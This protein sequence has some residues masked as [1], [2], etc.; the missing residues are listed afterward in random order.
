MTTA[1]RLPGNPGLD[2]EAAR[3]AATV[4]GGHT[5]RPA[6][7]ANAALLDHPPGRFFVEDLV[8]SATYSAGYTPSPGARWL[9][10]RWRTAPSA[11]ITDTAAVD[12]TLRD[13]GGAS[14]VSSNAMVPLGFKG[15][16][17]Y[18][19][20]IFALDRFT[21]CRSHEGWLDL[22]ALRSTLT[23][24]DWSLDFAVTL[25]GSGEVR[26]LEGWE[27][28]RNVLDD[29]VVAR[30]ILPGAF[31]PLRPV[32][33]GTPVGLERLLATIEAAR[34]TIRP[35]YLSL[36]FP[37][38]TT[39]ACPYV[40][41]TS[42]A[43]F[44]G[45]DEGASYVTLQVFVRR[46]FA[47]SSAGEP[48]RFRVLYRMSGGAGTETGKV[49]LITGASGS[50]FASNSLAY[51]TSWTWSPWIDAQ[52]ATNGAHGVDSLGL[53]GRM[54]AVGPTLHAAAVHVTGNAA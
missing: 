38:L 28:P 25:T 47:A 53:Q 13:T 50:P 10:L 44:A 4:R 3:V 20:A 36:A 49:R 46:L 54:S 15:E 52:L 30:G 48:S 27:L 9:Y 18:A 16:A 35:V 8:D 24:D 37:Q 19:P 42:Y 45:L 17:D 34:N 7:A 31:N 22:D 32:I 2:A 23:A 1:Q 29:S 51:T 33:D 12:L 39:S 6:M 43:A 26:T 21:D 11:T 41:G 40:T 14:V 5:F